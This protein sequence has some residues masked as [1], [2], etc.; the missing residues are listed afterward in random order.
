MPIEVIGGLA[1][2]SNKLA[3]S[4]GI[5][6]QHMATDDMNC[7]G[8]DETLRNRMVV[9]DPR[10]G[11]SLSPDFRGPVEGCSEMHPYPRPWCTRDLVYQSPGSG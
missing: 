1:K 11:P 2:H 3:S 10:G 5:V 8:C 7:Q 6:A 4:L 9:D